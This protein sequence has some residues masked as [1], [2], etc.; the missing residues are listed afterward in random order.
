MLANNLIPNISQSNISIVINFI[1][2]VY[3]YY[4][5]FEIM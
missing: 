5:F 3:F 4:I 2:F 1:L